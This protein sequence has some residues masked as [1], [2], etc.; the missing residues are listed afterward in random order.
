MLPAAER[1]IA[2]ADEEEGKGTVLLPC[3]TEGGSGG[4]KLI[5]TDELEMSGT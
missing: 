1:E 4:S 5:C 3:E 2:A